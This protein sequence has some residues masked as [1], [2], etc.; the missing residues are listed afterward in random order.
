MDLLDNPV[1]L[2][3]LE[4]SRR[5]DRSGWG[6]LVRDHEDMLLRVAKIRLDPRLAA[7]FDPADLVQEAFAD[8]YTQL[9]DYFR[10]RDAVSFAQWLRQ[11]LISRIARARRDHLVAQRRS[12]GKDHAWGDGVAM[13]VL[14]AIIDRGAGQATSSCITKRAC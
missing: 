13:A 9:D 6:H 1:T 5:G 7:R 4:R 14:G 2:E 12:V 11:R 3:I 8:A 10:D